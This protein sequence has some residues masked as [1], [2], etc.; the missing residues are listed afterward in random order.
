MRRNPVPVEMLH[1]LSATVVSG[2][3]KRKVF[4]TSRAH[5]LSLGCT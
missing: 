2:Q 5:G 4:Q 1:G 3:L